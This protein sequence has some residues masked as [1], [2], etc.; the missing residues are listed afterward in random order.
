[1]IK[2]VVFDFGKVMV[3]FE[4]SYM[5]G[6]YVTDPTDAKLLEQILF[7]RLYWDRA[8]AGTITDE[9]VIDACKTRL[10]EHLW[11]VS[12]KIYWNWI[13]NLPEI[14]GMRALVHRIKEKYGVRVFL[15]SNISAYF[16]AHSE[17][18][19][20]LAE[21][22]KCVY[23]A[24]CGYV[25]P[26]RKIFEHLCLTCAINP[27]ETLF[28]DDSEKNIQGAKSYGIEGYLFDGDANRLSAYLDTILT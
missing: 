2:N 8:D 9:E 3:H 24:V 11:E 5:V 12:E 20:C 27:T 17:E 6:K 13:Y 1:M 18:I 25:K 21:F 7:D 23:S 14:D 22:E 15:L 4:P 26:S 28:V 16:A 19:P 10:P